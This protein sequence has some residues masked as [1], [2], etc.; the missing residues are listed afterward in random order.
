MSCYRKFLFGRQRGQK[1]K[2]GP[3]IAFYKS[4]STTLHQIFLILYM[5]L[6]HNKCSLSASISGYRK[7]LLPRKRDQKVKIILKIRFLGSISRTLHQ[8]FLILHMIL[9][10]N[11][12]FLTAYVSCYQKFF[13]GRQSLQNVKISPKIGFLENISRTLHWNFLIL[14][15]MLDHNKCFLTAYVS[16]YRK[17]LFGRWKGQKSNLD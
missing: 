16:C 8:I 13:F 6:D 14:Y 5:M 4:I 9:D 1:V 17:F 15:M 10:H 3:K 11:K 7:V 12:C 2:I